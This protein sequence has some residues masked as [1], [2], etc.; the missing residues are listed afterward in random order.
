MATINKKGYMDTTRDATGIKKL[1]RLNTLTFLIQST[2]E[3]SIF[4]EDKKGSLFQSNKHNNQCKAV[5]LWQSVWAFPSN[6]LFLYMYVQ[7][8]KEPKAEIEYRS[9]A[10]VINKYTLSQSHEWSRSETA[11]P[12]ITV[13]HDNN[14][15]T[16]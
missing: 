14:Q 8:Y 10:V 5:H 1:Q 11:V 12:V 2:A 3:K 7:K 16:S 13:T 15:S 9:E 6:V 4:R